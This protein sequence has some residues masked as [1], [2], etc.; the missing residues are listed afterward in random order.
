MTL[1]A[2]VIDDTERRLLK[3]PR[4]LLVAHGSAFDQND[5]EIERIKTV[6]SSRIQF[7][8]TTA[9][10]DPEEWLEMTGLSGYRSRSWPCCTSR[11]RIRAMF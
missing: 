10:A 2:E 5:I 3:I 4:R 11:A 6:Y 8:F 9:I 1:T 7:N